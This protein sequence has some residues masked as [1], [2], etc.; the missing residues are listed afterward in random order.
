MTTDAALPTCAQHPDRETRVACPRCGRAACDLCLPSPGAAGPQICSSCREDVQRGDATGAGTALRAPAQG[1]APVTFTL[2]GLFVVVFVAG[3]LTGDDVSPI[4][5]YGAQINALVEAGQWWRVLTATMLHADLTH[6]LFNG[7]ALYILGAQLER[8]VGSRAFAALYVAAGIAGGIAFLVT[9]PGQVA[10]GASGAIF[11]LFGAWFA[12]SWVNRHTPQGRAGLSQ[13]GLLLLINL[14]LPLF[15]P[16]IAWE[17][18]LGGLVAGAVIGLG[19]ARSSR[20]GRTARP[21]RVLLPSVL[22]VVL[23]LALLWYT[24]A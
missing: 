2:L 15:V 17:A 9:S 14:A 3:L 10:V 5:L 13:F 21:S 23:S 20:A 19:W 24:M 16:N 11:G 12:A 4:L 6:L 8:G 18:H 22:I 7:Y 1:G